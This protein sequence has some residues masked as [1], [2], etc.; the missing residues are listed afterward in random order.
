MEH[1]KVLYSLTAALGALLLSPLLE[2]FHRGGMDGGIVLQVF[3]MAILGT[4]FLLAGLCG[5]GSQCLKSNQSFSALQS[6]LAGDSGKY[7]KFFRVIIVLGV[8]FL[9]AFPTIGFLQKYMDFALFISIY[10]YYLATLLFCLLGGAGLL[11]IGVCGVARQHFNNH[12]NLFTILVAILI[13]SLILM[14]FIYW[15]TGSPTV[16]L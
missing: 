6:R 12:K 5:F 8:A 14:P 9:V 13:P 7:S 3:F 15:W 4:V 10:D 2:S 11:T 1:P 16:G